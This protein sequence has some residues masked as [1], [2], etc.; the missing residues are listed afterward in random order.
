MNQQERLIAVLIVL[1]IA[2]HVFTFGGQIY[3]ARTYGASIP[4]D[5]QLYWKNFS[6]LVLSLANIGAGLWLYFE[7]RA[8]RVAVWV[9]SMFGL[10]FGLEGVIVF[11]L[12]QL[13][14][15]KRATET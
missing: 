9:W 13:Y 10:T 6:I 1:V 3:L 7:A 2:S 5:V 4:L 11:Y 12:V 8:A 14:G 15:Q